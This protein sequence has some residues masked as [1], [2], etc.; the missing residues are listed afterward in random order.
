MD[1]PDITLDFWTI[2]FL[3]AGAQACFFSILILLLNQEKGKGRI[4]LS[5][6][7]FLFGYMLIFNFCYWTNYLYRFPALLHTISPL[8]YVFGPLLLLYFDKQRKEPKL[9]KFWYLHFIPVVLVFLHL[10]PFYLADGSSKLLMISGEMPFPKGLLFRYVGYLYTPLVFG[11]YMIAYFFWKIMLLL[12]IYSED[13]LSEKSPE[14][15]LIRKRWFLV[16]L[17]LYAAF[18]SSYLIYYVISG[19]EFFTIAYDYA[20]TAVMTV[21]I[22]SL[23]YLGIKRNFILSGE[24]HRKVFTK[25]KYANSSLSL[26][27]AESIVMK[28]ENYMKDEKL[29]LQNDLKLID[30]ANRLTISPHHLSQVINEHHGKSFNQ[31]VNEYRIREAQALLSKPENREEHIIQIAYQVG[32]NNK[33]TF[34]Q[35]FKKVLGLTP[36]QYRKEVFAE[37]L[38]NP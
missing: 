35:A 17:S 11:S 31:Y 2:L 16:L 22:Y 5:V 25:D 8:N 33:S 30:L 27:A 34:N 3:V 18:M 23:A 20:I 15:I 13:G 38:N 24:L 10:S 4:Y 36:S 32:F 12:K 28:T 9:Q 21:S 26:G 29:F 6:F 19:K 37:S 14:L 1:I 7:L